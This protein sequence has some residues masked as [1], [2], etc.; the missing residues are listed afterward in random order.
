MDE[1]I[2]A[3]RIARVRLRGPAAAVLGL[4][5]RL[6]PMGPDEFVEADVLLGED[7]LAR[8]IRFTY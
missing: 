8:A 4:D 7:G 2:G 3:L 5:G 6:P 1:E